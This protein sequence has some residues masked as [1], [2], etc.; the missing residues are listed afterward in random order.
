MT[1]TQEDID[2]IAQKIVGVIYSSLFFE[3]GTRSVAESQRT[4]SLIMH[5]SQFAREMN[6]AYGTRARKSIETLCAVLSERGIAWKEP[7]GDHL[8]VMIGECNISVAY[9]RGIEIAL[10]STKSGRPRLYMHCTASESDIADFIEFIAAADAASHILVEK[11]YQE[12]GRNRMISEVEYP[13]VEKEVA[14]F[15]VPRGIKY[16]LDNNRGEN[17]LSIQILKEIWMQKIV[18]YEDIEQDLRLVPYLIKRPD[19]IKRDGR[20]FAIFH[21]WNWDKR[22]K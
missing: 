22:R 20:G 17:I 11:R 14:E 16:T 18:S 13:G 8:S 19:C 15:L 2:T 12:A 4:N 9:N 1:Y 21:N 3:D 6:S 5:L 10:D 7:T